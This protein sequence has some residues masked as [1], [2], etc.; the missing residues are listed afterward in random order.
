MPGIITHKKIFIDSMKLLSGRKNRSYLLQSIAALLANPVQ[1]Q[2]ALFGVLGPNIFDYIP[3]A[4]GKKSYGHPISFAIHNGETPELLRVMIEQICLHEDKNN[5]WSAMQRAYLY[6]FISHLIADE[7]IHPY[8]L[9]MSGYPDTAK[10]T[11]YFREQNLLFQYNIDN[12]FLYL[13]EDRDELEFDIREMIPFV[14]KKSKRLNAPIK[15]F[16]LHSLHKT[17]PSFYN[18]I[19][20]KDLK[21]DSPNFTST[22]GWLDIIPLL[23]IKSQN[24]KMNYNERVRKIM[25]EINHRRFFYSDFLIQYQ[26]P[27]KTNTHYLNLHREGWSNPAGSS[28]LRYESIPHLCRAACEKTVS[29]WEEIEKSLYSDGTEAVEKLVNINA[30]TGNSQ[31][32]YFSMKRKNPVKLRP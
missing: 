26:W 16:I 19:I 17:Y 8:V 5:E 2:A 22:F 30:Y 15:E 14:S 1:K 3:V 4:F 28:A 23:I 7:I 25:S 29:I 31:E 20:W 9:Y 32:D 18:K 27:K 6:G 11:S 10:D 24:L 12:Y 13:A 21:E